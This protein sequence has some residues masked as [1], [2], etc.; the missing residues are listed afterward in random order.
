[1]S[2]V[3]TPRT[4][5]ST[6]VRIR[7]IEFAN[8]RSLV[9][10]LEARSLVHPPS[11]ATGRFCAGKLI[12]RQL[13]SS[14]GE[15]PSDHSHSRSVAPPRHPTP[16]L[17]RSAESRE[18]PGSPEGGRTQPRTA[19]TAAATGSATDRVG[20]AT[21]NPGCP[22]HGPTCQQAGNHDRD[23]MKRRC[24]ENSDAAFRTGWARA[25]FTYN[26]ARSHPYE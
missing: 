13:H 17:L 23:V 11:P 20:D 9:T 1:V 25:H 21:G 24:A 10:V 8:R 6:D 22:I 19:P 12:L 14:I 7:E 3:A 15:L 4:G 18:F 26:C 5:R 2:P 16:C